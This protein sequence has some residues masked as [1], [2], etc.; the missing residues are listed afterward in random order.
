MI[1][2]P[3][4]TARPR[5]IRRAAV[6]R[7]IRQL[8]STRL[9]LRGVALLLYSAAVLA[10]RI[11]PIPRRRIPLR[12]VQIAP[13]SFGDDGVV[14]GG[15][16]YPVALAEAMA[17]HVDTVFVSFGSER[18]TI[19]RGA[20]RIE[21]YPALRL[22]NGMP[23]DPVSYEFLEQLLWADVVHCH[24]YRTLVTNLAIVAGAALRRAVFLTDLGGA[25]S[26]FSDSL[27]ISR[28]VTAVLPVS[29]FGARTLGLEAPTRV[30]FGGVG[31]H[32]IA[33]ATEVPRQR[34][35][36]FVG[37]LLPHKGIDVL[38]R[39]IDPDVTLEIIGRPYNPE[40]FQLLQELAAGKD[41]RFVTDA[42]DEDLHR[43]YR[44]AAVTVLPSVY[45]DVYGTRHAVPE[46]LGL[47]L[48]ESMACGT[49]TICTD[50]GGMP[51]F[52][53]DGV[54]GFVVPPNDPDALRERI[55]HLVRNPEIVAQMGQRGRER[56]LERFTWD[57][58]ARRCLAAYE[59]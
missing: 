8:V 19:R 45:L 35:V 41:V 22:M 26:H 29:G 55:N 52:V 53:E 36:L 43:A 42:S 34:K 27:P 57:A 3:G 13:A 11:A 38:I 18:R 28:F 24:Q 2:R 15:E 37:R 23:F 25:A 50:V 56:V 32:L 31:P 10:R 6:P 30:I 20:L 21:I 49:P 44:E 58:V 33:D 12:V 1:G 46:L 9:A 39:A 48:L 51:E 17:R 14:G 47:V 40:Y 59:A 4:S 7:M 16:R 54:T 5:G